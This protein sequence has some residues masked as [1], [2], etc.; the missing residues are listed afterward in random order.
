MVK[1]QF[2]LGIADF[3]EAALMVAGIEEHKLVC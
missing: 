3:S 2:E 1:L